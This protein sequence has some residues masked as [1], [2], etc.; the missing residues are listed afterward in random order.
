M[1]RE[2]HPVWAVYDRLR[3]ARLN[4]KY[5]CER[6]RQVELLNRACEIILLIAAPTSAIAGLWFWKTDIGKAVWQ[7]L[8]IVSAIIA[9]VRPA[10]QLTKKIKDYEAAIS[11]YQ[12][13]EYDLEIIRQKIEQRG[14]YDDKLKAEFMKAVER[15]RNVELA[16]PDKVPN[17]KLLQN[18]T[19]A[20]LAEMPANSFFVPET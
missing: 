20:V 1:N 18:C 5:Y 7:S 2:Q 11:G 8:G 9:T 10:F 4:V 19:N 6:L 14:T 15:H 13:L 3:T 16:S 12:T 17:R